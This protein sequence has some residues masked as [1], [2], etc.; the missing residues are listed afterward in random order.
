MC[1]ILEM[2]DGSRGARLRLLGGV[3]CML[4][5]SARHRAAVIAKMRDAV[6]RMIMMMNI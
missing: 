5:E 2:V 6:V 4:T 1:V 3:R